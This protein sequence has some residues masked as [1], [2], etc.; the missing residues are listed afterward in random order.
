MSVK[1]LLHHAPDRQQPEAAVPFGLISKLVPRSVQAGEPVVPGPVVDTVT[2]SMQQAM[3]HQLHLITTRG[4]VR[5]VDSNKVT[6]SVEGAFYLEINCRTPQPDHV[7][8]FEIVKRLRHLE[9]VRK[10]HV[11]HLISGE[12]PQL[13]FINRDRPTRRILRLQRQI[14]IR[15]RS[16]RFRSLRVRL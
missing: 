13:R 3:Q 11:L 8:Q 1:S 6:F 2:R 15:R 16:H 7:H 4:N 10:Q 9:S 5:K 14:K 12:E